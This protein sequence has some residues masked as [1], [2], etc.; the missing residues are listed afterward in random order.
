MLLF[1]IM[2]ALV[3]LMTAHY[4]VTQVAFCRSFFALL[5]I[6]P[7]FLAQGAKLGQSG[8]WLGHA[9]RGAIGIAGMLTVYLSYA[10][11]PLA[12]AVAL[13]FTVPLWVTAFAGPLL[14]ERADARAWGAVVVGF[15]G[16]LVIFPPTGTADWLSVAFGLL[17][18]GLIALQITLIRRLGRTDST[19]R[20]VFYYTMALAAGTAVLAP[21]DWRTPSLDH[22]GILVA[23]GVLGGVAHLCM[24]QA[25]RVAPAASV[26]PFDYTG[27]LWSVLFGL[28]LWG[29]QP[30]ANLAAGAAI[31]IASGIYVL[32]RSR[33]RPA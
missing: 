7:L 25:Y 33:R 26:A 31:I 16:V 5:A 8:W 9:L 32:Q 2:G 13:T 4:A 28:L 24:T 11:L 20:I 30:S 18:N 23:I 27:L 21:I 19:T 14:G 10:R 22:A 1:S 15:A 6:L 17:G 29:E 12:D 3:K